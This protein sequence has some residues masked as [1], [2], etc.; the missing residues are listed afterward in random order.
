MQNLP[1][2]SLQLQL[3]LEILDQQGRAPRGGMATKSSVHL[4]DGAVLLG[5]LIAAE[6]LARIESVLALGVVSFVHGLL[7]I[8]VNAVETS[9][10]SSFATINASETTCW[11]ELLAISLVETDLECKSSRLHLVKIE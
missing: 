11:R 8:A 2:R 9:V 6:F 4:L 10:Y 1:R 3:P 7:R 5:D